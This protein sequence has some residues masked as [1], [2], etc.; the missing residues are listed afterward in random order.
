DRERRS[1][2]VALEL[3]VRVVGVSP[4]GRQLAEEPAPK[5]ERT[6][7]IGAD[8]LESDRNALRGIVLL[9]IF[10]VV[11]MHA[12][13]RGH[14]LLAVVV[15]DRRP[16]AS[17]HADPRKAGSGRLSFCRAVGQN[18][19]QVGGLEQFRGFLRF[20]GRCSKQFL[21]QGLGEDETRNLDVVCLPVA[22]I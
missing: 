20:L 17:T 9:A 14:A 8:L 13:P 5:D 7:Q 19:A 16:K 4:T 2:L 21:A 3:G 10:F 1:D 6:P 11:M 12:G 15:A 22:S 18:A